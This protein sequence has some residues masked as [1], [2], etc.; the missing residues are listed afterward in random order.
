[1]TE[2]IS[3]SPRA[4]GLTCSAASTTRSSKKYSP[5]T[6]QL[7][8]GCVG[9]LLDL[10]GPTVGVEVD[11]AVALWVLDVVAEH[12]GAGRPGRRGGDEVG[13]AGAVE[14][15]VAEHE[16]CA[17]PVEEVGADQERL[18]EPVGRVLGGVG[19]L[20]SPLRAV[21][22]Q[23][24]ERGTVLG[25][26]DDQHLADAG[27]HVHRQRVVDHRLVVHR[28]QLLR[29]AQRDRV[30]TRARSPGEDDALHVAEA[31]GPASSFAGARRDR[32]A[33]PVATV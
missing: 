22:E 3:S 15:V 19:E 8:V 12:R 23:P 9:L 30:E 20:Q 7:L 27:E 4:D 32:G 1:M 18:G 33:R 17:L 14:Q 13:Q 26:G 10:G 2:V 6:A 25:R 11:D 5:V 16:R 31:T 24:L 29:R 28:Q 21:A